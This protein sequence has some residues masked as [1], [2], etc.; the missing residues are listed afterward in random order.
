G[1]TR[2]QVAE[3]VGGASSARDH[4]WAVSV[5][6]ARY[7]RDVGLGSQL[8]RDLLDAPARGGAVHVTRADE[9]DHA[10]L[11]LPGGGVL[12]AVGGLDRLRRRVLSSVGAEVLSHAESEGAGDRGTDN[13]D[14]QYAAAVGV[15]ERG[16]SREHDYSLS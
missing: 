15:Q 2:L 13:R 3:D 4:R 5:I 1:R 16:E 9:R 8:H 7:L 12:V 11:D 10:R 6:E 14:E